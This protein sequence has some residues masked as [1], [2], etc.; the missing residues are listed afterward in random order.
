MYYVKETKTI[1][2]KIVP[3][4]TEYRVVETGRMI[5]VPY[6]PSRKVSPVE[7]AYYGGGYGTSGISLETFAKTYYKQ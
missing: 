7:D 2:R 6:T 1:K 3:G 5:A 4:V